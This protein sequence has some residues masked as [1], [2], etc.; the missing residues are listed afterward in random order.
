ML[1]FE[2]DRL[3]VKG[4]TQ[5]DKAYFAELFTDPKVLEL[6]PQ[7]AFTAAQITHRFNNNLNLDLSR[8]QNEK[9]VFGIYEIGQS[10]LIGLCLFLINADQEYELGYRFRTAFWGKGYA[11]ETTKGMLDYYFNIMQVEAVTADVNIANPASVKILQKFMSP[12][13]SFYNDRDHC[14][15]RRFKIQKDDYLKENYK[16]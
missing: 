3:Q 13:Q 4:L 11:T 9:C 1:L 12:I 8:L 14:T 6:I 10:E 2:T 7:K 15:D 5:K 16:L